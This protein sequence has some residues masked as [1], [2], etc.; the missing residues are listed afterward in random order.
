MI[1]EEELTPEFQIKFMV[2]PGHSLQNGFRLL[3]E[4]LLVIES[5]LF[6]NTACLPA[7]LIIGRQAGGRFSFSPHIIAYFYRKA[8]LINRGTVI[9]LNKV[10]KNTPLAASSV[11]PPNLSVNMGVVDAEGIAA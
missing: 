2:K 5:Y 1:I 3:G 10:V 7:L 6:H 4:I 9:M 8:K 11:S